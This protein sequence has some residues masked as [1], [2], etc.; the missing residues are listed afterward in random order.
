MKTVVLP[1]DRIYSGNLIL[2]NAQYPYHEGA[3][4]PTLL[5]IHP[6]AGQILLEAHAV[7]FPI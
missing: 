6:T 5:P 3:A 4:A 7:L 2:V 1:N